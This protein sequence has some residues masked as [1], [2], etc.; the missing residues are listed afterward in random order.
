MKPLFERVDLRGFEH[1]SLGPVSKSRDRLEILLCALSVGGSRHERRKFRFELRLAQ[2]P[3]GERTAQFRPIR[4][5]QSPSQ[6]R[7]GVV[8]QEL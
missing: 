4:V 1:A 6:R 2:E 5:G 8:Q 3:C 7:T